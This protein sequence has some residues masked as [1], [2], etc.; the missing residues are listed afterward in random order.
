MPVPPQ[1]EDGL[2][3]Q[4][5]AKKENAFYFGV[6]AGVAAWI[7]FGGIALTAYYCCYKRS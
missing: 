6:I 1:F 3:P 5:E 4:E 7:I 2:G